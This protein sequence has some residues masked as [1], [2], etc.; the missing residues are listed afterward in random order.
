MGPQ[1]EPEIPSPELATPTNPGRPL[2]PE[3]RHDES[4]RQNSFKRRSYSTCEP[5]RNQEDVVALPHPHRSMVE[6]D[7]RREDRTDSRPDLT[8]TCKHVYQP[9]ILGG[10]LFHKRPTS[11]TRP[12]SALFGYRWSCSTSAEI[13][14]TSTGR[15]QPAAPGNGC[16][17]ALPDR[18]FSA[19]ARVRCV[20]TAV[21]PARASR[22]GSGPTLDSRS[23]R[24]PEPEQETVLDAE[25]VDP[26]LPHG[27]RH[28]GNRLDW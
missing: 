15:V 27:S 2:Q 21:T 9:S 1:L 14:H 23:P 20:S 7:T 8:D 17:S 18:S 3:L 12:T 19:P 24:S 5:T 25:A 26:K 11:T 10:R 6:F 13:P 16:L 28:P 22:C 4:G